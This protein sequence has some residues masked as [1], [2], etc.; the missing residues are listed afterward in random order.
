MNGGNFVMLNKNINML[1][2]VCFLAFGA[3]LFVAEVAYAAEVLPWD[4]AL[5]VVKK[6]VTGPIALAV[7]IVAIVAV[8]ITLIFGGDMQGFVR[9]LLYVAMVVGLI[10][11]ASTVLDK[12]YNN[13]DATSALITITSAVE[14]YLPV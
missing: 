4:S 3:M 8:G 14:Y 13:K 10:V 1:M 12:L 9:Q 2:V 11:M 7:S 5:T 6:S